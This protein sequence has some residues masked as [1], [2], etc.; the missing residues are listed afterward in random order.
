VYV[1]GGEHETAPVRRNRIKIDPSEGA[2]CYHCV[3]RTVNGEFLFDEASK[4]VLRCM[5]WKVADF[6]GLEVLTYAI[7]SNHFH[8]L[9]RVPRQKPVSDEELFRRY[10]SL[11]SSSS[12]RGASRLSVV[13]AL[14]AAG[15]A[16]AEGWRRRQLALM[17]DVSQF[18]KLLKQRFSIWFN[19]AHHRFGTLWAERFRSVLI[20]SSE[21]VL[22]TV[23]AYVDLNSVRAGIVSD[24]KDYRFCG[25]AEAVAGSRVARVGLGAIFP[26][27]D[28][29]SVQAA[30]R[31]RLFASGSSQREGGAKIAP[32][33]LAR[34]IAERGK[35][36]LATVLMCRVR[37]FTFG[38]VLGGEAF[39]KTQFAS[40]LA[41]EASAPGRSA[42]PLLPLTDW[43]DLRTMVAVRA[44][45][46][47]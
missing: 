30:Y 15:D 41:S 23:A 16:A 20:E 22:A 10:A 5:L 32:A 38:A 42:T 17:G 1:S 39:V 11:H 21:F 46:S 40:S 28:W 33:D 45:I 6:C 4:E 36:P 26:P 31:M 18:M 3:T 14:L 2:A 13:R 47:C 44:P 25:Y 34:V 19:K 8:V 7:L 35:L 9:V 29:E 27:Q 37:Y 12:G 43:D 24:P